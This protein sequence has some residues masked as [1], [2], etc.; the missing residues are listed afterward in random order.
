MLSLRVDQKIKERDA[1]NYKE[2]GYTMKEL[3][4]IMLVHLGILAIARCI[5]K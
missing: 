3:L 1:L 5:I 4:L 2:G